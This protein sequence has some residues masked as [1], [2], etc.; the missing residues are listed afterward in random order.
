M[1]AMNDRTKMM[2]AD[3]LMSMLEEMPFGKIRV[4]ELCRRCGVSTRLFYYHFSDKDE[5]A[6]WVFRSHYTTSYSKQS[7]KEGRELWR[8]LTIIQFNRLWEHRDFYRRMFMD[9][10]GNSLRNYIARFSEEANI[11][12][13]KKYLATDKLDCEDLFLAKFYASGSTS[14]FVEWILGT[15]EMGAEKLTDLLLDAA[16]PL[17][18]KAYSSSGFLPGPYAKGEFFG[19]QLGK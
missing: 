1:T 13:L 11:Y 2:F 19:K 15:Y 8:E 3:E 17:I 12:S 7:D 18:L 14:V 9:G 4:S 6:A 16:P 5:L 10:S